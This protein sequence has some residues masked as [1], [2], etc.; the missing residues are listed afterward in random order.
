MNQNEV[1]DIIKEA[2]EY[3]EKLYNGMNTLVNNIDNR[4]LKELD[5]YVKNILE[6]FNWLLEIIVVSKINIYNPLE[7][8]I[9]H[10]KINKYVE[11]YNNIDILLIRDIL[12]CE[13]MP[14]VEI[15]YSIFDEYLI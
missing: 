3:C 12:E 7:L 10:E 8:N 9:I 5:V 15:F 4:T 13:L 1:C 6:G 2:H 11:A 14:Y